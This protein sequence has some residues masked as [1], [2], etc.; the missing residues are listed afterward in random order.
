MGATN[1]TLER[2]RLLTISKRLLVTWR[3]ICEIARHQH[4][5]LGKTGHPNDCLQHPTAAWSRDIRGGFPASSPLIHTKG[6]ILEKARTKDY[7][8]WPGDRSCV[9]QQT[10]ICHTFSANKERYSPLKHLNL[11]PG[12]LLGTFLLTRVPK[13]PLQRSPVARQRLS[14]PSQPSP[15]A[16]LWYSS[17]SWQDFDSVY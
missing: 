12:R 13:H 7:P 10:I 3:C 8:E 4:T 14:R 6:A 5:P 2:R 11:A 1:L 9:P 15:L 17:A 16:N